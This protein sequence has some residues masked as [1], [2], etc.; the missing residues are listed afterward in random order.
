MTERD[1]DRLAVLDRI[2]DRV[3]ELDLDQ[4]RVDWH[5]LP[6]GHEALLVDGGG[7][8]GG[9]GV[10]FAN[11]GNDLH[12]VGALAPMIPGYVGCIVIRPDKTRQLAHVEP[13]PLAGQKPD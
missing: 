2:A 7:I 10:Y 9:P 13:D 11:A 5:E 1:A 6:D 3:P 4:H 12:A 8:D